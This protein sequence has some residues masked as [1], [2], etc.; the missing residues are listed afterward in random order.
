MSEINGTAI[1]LHLINGHSYGPRVAEC[2]TSP[3]RV[4]ASRWPEH[5]ALFSSGLP[6]AP[7]VYVFT[8]PAQSGAPLLAVRPGEAMDIRRRL[9]EHAL[10]STKARFHEIFV[11]SAVDGRLGKADI[12]YLEARFHE[13]VAGMPGT[14]LEVDK[15]PSVAN[16]HPWERDTLEV[17]IS[18]ARLLLH[19]AGCRALDSEGLPLAAIVPDHELE[20]A[21]RLDFDIEGTLGDEHELNYDGIWA[22]GFPHR[23]GFVVRAGS[24]VRRR[25]NSALLGPMSE[26]RRFLQREGALGEIP[27]VT[28]RWRLMRN[29]MVTSE[30]TAAK[31]LTGAHQSN[32][33][34]WRRLS[35][36]ARIIVAK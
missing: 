22:R 30:L 15:I 13:L 12:R 5:P 36:A 4:H 21:V 25:E 19:A 32:R 1:T 14:V 3:L 10:D 33:G 7:A 8:G 34:I 18:Q 35:P 2:R 6:A 9:L 23:D 27:G 28:D 31:V 16:C 17:L 11:L 24:D 26:R 29:I 20:A